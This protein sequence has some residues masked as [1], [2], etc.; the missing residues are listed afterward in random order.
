MLVTLSRETLQD[1]VVVLVLAHFVARIADD[2]GGHTALK[3]C[4]VKKICPTHFV[5]PG[6]QP[7]L[8]STS[9]IT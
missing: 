4:E 2:V 9:Q 3:I 1:A 7:V 6:L 5:S 8:P